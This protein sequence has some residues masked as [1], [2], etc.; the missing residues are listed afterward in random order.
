[1][2]VTIDISRRCFELIWHRWC[3]WRNPS[4]TSEITRVW[5]WFL[6]REG[7]GGFYCCSVSLTRLHRG[8]YLSDITTLGRLNLKPYLGFQATLLYWKKASVHSSTFSCSCLF[9]VYGLWYFMFSDNIHVCENIHDSFHF[10]RNPDSL[11]MKEKCRFSYSTDNCIAPI[12][13]IQDIYGF[14][15][16]C[17]Q[18]YASC[19]WYLYLVLFKIDTES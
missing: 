16:G 8:Q 19:H 15:W 18:Q 11:G 2:R 1:M 14:L 6:S 3:L 5:Q 17:K 13:N 10:A 9:Y 4:Q 7:R 12:V